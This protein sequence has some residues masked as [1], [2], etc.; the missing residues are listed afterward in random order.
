MTIADINLLFIW[1]WPYVLNTPAVLM[2]CVVLQL[3][4]RTGLRCFYCQMFKT[5]TWTLLDKRMVFVFY[6][7]RVSEEQAPHRP[8][9]SLKQTLINLSFWV[10]SISFRQYSKRN[11]ARNKQ[12]SVVHIWILTYD[13][14]WSMRSCAVLWIKGRLVCLYS[15]YSIILSALLRFKMVNA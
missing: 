9:P 13:A 15:Q 2:L 14:K 4:H 11:D 6:P 7:P 10:Q 8:L 1:R 3:P 12:D 5:K